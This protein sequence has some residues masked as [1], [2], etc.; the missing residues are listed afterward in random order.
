M[1]AIEENA[2]GKTFFAL[3]YVPPYDFSPFAFILRPCP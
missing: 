2:K 3:S 1:R